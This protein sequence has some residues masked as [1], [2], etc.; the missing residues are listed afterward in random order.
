[1][2]AYTTNEYVTCKCDICGDKFEPHHIHH[3]PS[4]GKYTCSKCYRILR[5]GKICGKE[6]NIDEGIRTWNLYSSASVRDLQ[7]NTL[8]KIWS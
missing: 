1:M 5:K 4:L 6:T 2:K 8:N 3:R 7:R